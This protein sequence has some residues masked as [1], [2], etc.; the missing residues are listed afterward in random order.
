MDRVLMLLCLALLLVQPTSASAGGAPELDLDEFPLEL[1]DEDADEDPTLL[2][3]SHL[4]EIFKW[5][6][7]EEEAADAGEVHGWTRQL[8]GQHPGRPLVRPGPGKA[9]QTVV[10]IPR[11]GPYRVWLSCLTKIGDKHPVRLRL[12]GR[13]R[14]DH[15]FGA[16]PMPQAG[17]EEAE[18]RLP[19]RFDHDEDRSM[20]LAKK[21][22]VWEYWDTELEAGTTVLSLASSD[23]SARLDALFLSRSKAFAPGGSRVVG[24]HGTLNRMYYRF[25]V[26]PEDGSV[27]EVTIQGSIAFIVPPTTRGPYHAGLGDVT[28]LDGQR[29]IPVGEWSAWLDAVEATTTKGTYANAVLTVEVARNRPLDRG[30]LEVQDAWHAHPG[31]VMATAR[32][33][34]RDG[35]AAVL[36]PAYWKRFP[37]AECPAPGQGGRA[38]F[39]VRHLAAEQELRSHRREL[40]I[41]VARIPEESLQ[42]GVMPRLLRIMTLARVEPTE[43]EVAIPL[44][45]RAGFNCLY[46]ISQDAK[47]QYGLHPEDYKPR[48]GDMYRLIVPLFWKY[49]HRL[50]HYRTGETRDPAV[51]A[52]ARKLEDEDPAYRHHAHWTPMGDEIGPAVNALSVN[53]VPAQC[54]AFHDYLRQVSDSDPS[55]F[56][57]TTF[58]V[59]DF[60]GTATPRMNRCERRRYYHSA[61]FRWQATAEF[62]R[63]RTDILRRIF[64]NIRTMANYSPYTVFYFGTGMDRG[65]NSFALPRANACT[66][67]WGEDWLSANGVASLA[68]VQT[69]SFFASV[70]RCGASRHGQPVGI[71]LVWKLGELDRKM[72]LLVSHGIRNVH[73]YYWGPRYLGGGSPESSRHRVGSYAELNRAAR[74]FG[75]ADETI[76]RGTRE[77]A[78]VAL[79]YNRTAEMWNDGNAWCR[80]DRIY[81]FLALR[82]AQVPVDLVL[83]EDLTEERL[84]PYRVLYLNGTNIRRDALKAAA[85]WVERGGIVYAVS[86]TAMRDEYDDPLPEAQALFGARPVPGGGSVGSQEVYQEWLTAHEPVDTVTIRE[87]RSRARRAC[88]SLG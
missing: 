35:K 59:L 27:K 60:V 81:T 19:V 52:Y 20:Y 76:V 11:P 55:F 46:P 2:G 36:V 23:G 63:K 7:V 30:V 58:D 43:Y 53:T 45:K 79:L 47:R 77:P 74:A 28:S 40:E 13:N 51:E 26:S 12:E 86:A 69:E 37:T 33:P 5:P 80:T 18:A 78:R 38:P 32:V 39:V 83:E 29:E 3:I 4:S 71:Y 44:L 42:P 10:N 75:P 15:L 48:G 61:V 41:Q 50:E 16:A 14:G 88:R 84:R 68:G 66:G 9:I 17:A 31:A 72:G 56:G 62:Y 6:G 57:A 8:T 64:P 67:H 22:I 65:Q 82:H 34:I 70:L 73:V 25:R 21:V 87:S 49:G 85:R 1:E 24:Q 54:R